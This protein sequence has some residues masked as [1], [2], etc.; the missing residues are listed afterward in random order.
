MIQSDRDADMPT[1]IT[2][3]PPTTIQTQTPTV[4]SL[5]QNQILDHTQITTDGIANDLILKLVTH[6]NTVDHITP[7]FDYFLIIINLTED[8]KNPLTQP[9][10]QLETETHELSTT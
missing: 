6:P 4:A 10:V 1:L 8:A 9:I 2:T 3:C 5:T 7:N